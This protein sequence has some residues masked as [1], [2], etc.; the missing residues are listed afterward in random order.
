[1]VVLQTISNFAPAADMVGALFCE[2]RR[3]VLLEYRQR[4]FKQLKVFLGGMK[5]AARNFQSGNLL[6]LFSYD[7]SSL[8][9]VSLRDLKL[10][11]FHG[12]PR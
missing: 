1:M 6:T 11:F 9:D 8:G 10:C 3:E 2:K 12:K 7:T 5:I 4:I